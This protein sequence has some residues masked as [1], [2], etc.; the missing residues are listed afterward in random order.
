MAEIQVTLNSA[1]ITKATGLCTQY[2]IETGY[3]EVDFGDGPELRADNR[4]NPL[5]AAL[6]KYQLGDEWQYRIPEIIQISHL[7][8]LEVTPEGLCQALEKGLFVFLNLPENSGI[9]SS[10]K[11]GLHNCIPAMVELLVPDDKEF[12]AAAKEFFEQATT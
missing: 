10:V 4:V 3:H 1:D 9:H 5:F 7:E 12:V 11:L 2:S 6:E 8:G